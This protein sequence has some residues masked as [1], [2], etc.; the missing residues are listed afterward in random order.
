[1]ITR[2]AG[3]TG[4]DPGHPLAGDVIHFWDIGG[5]DT[6]LVS[7]D[8][9]ATTAGLVSDPDL[10]D[11][12]RF[13]SAGTAITTG[14]ASSGAGSVV[15]VL[16]PEVSYNAGGSEPLTLLNLTASGHINTTSLTSGLM[17]NTYS[18]IVT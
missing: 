8:A 10:G 3:I 1:M 6:D 5:T 12:R 15:F 16:R 13:D 4:V 18:I 14:W 11:C 9:I 2:P 7:G 17:V